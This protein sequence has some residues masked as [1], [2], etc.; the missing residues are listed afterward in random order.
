M[1]AITVLLLLGGAILTVIGAA[2][3]D[4][5]ILKRTSRKIEYLR[6][7]LTTLAMF[8]LGIAAVIAGTILAY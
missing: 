3:I 2:R 8:S 7:N 4:D 5:A 1:F 6:E